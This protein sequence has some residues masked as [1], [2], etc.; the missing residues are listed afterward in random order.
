MT[1]KNYSSCFSHEKWWIFHIFHSFLYVYQAGSP[2]RSP[3]AYPKK[4]RLSAE[5]KILGNDTGD[6]KMVNATY[7]LVI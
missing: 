2:R 1:I 6:V 5:V 7:R 4:V 3:A